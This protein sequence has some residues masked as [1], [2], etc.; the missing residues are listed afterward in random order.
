MR[1]L[2]LILSLA[3]CAPGAMQAQSVPPRAAPSAPLPLPFVATGNEPG[4]RLDITAE[5]I[6]LVADYGATKLSMRWRPPEPVAGGRRYAG[7]ADGRVLVVTVLDHPCVD[8]M[9]GMPRPNT[10]AVTLDEDA[11][12]GC[13]GNPATLLLGAP[14]VVEDIGGAGLVEGSRAT[15]AFGDDGRVTGSASCNSYTAGYSL[16]AEALTIERAAAT[17]KACAPALMTQEQALLD[18]LNAVMRFEVAGDGALVLHAAD[19]R[20]VRARR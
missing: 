4:W 12:R 8:D 7:N 17:R 2:L 1:H 18:V 10:V 16:S 5:A 11:L 3:A 19:G 9:T 15:I 20:T 14:W 6:T 13:G